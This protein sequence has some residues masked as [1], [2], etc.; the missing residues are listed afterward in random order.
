MNTLFANTSRC[1]F[2][3]LLIPF[4]FACTGLS[5]FVT[6]STEMAGTIP[7]LLPPLSVLVGLATLCL[8]LIQLPFV[9][10]KNKIWLTGINA[11]FF[12]CGFLLW[13]QANVFNWNFGELDGSGVNWD[14]FRYLMWLEICIYVVVIGFILWR[15]Q[16]FS[17]YA[18]QFACV[19]MLMQAIPL[20]LPVANGLAIG[21]PQ[22]ADD[23]PNPNIAS[24]KQYEITYDGFFDYS[25]EQNVVLIIPDCFNTIAFQHIIEKWPEV[26]EWFSDFN[27]FPNRQSD[28]R[29]MVSIPQILTG[30]DTILSLK[31]AD[32][33]NDDASSLSIQRSLWNS[34]GALQKTLTEAGFRT[35]LYVWPKQPHYFDHRWISNIRIKDSTDVLLPRTCQDNLVKAGIGQICDLAIVRSI[36]IV[37][38]PIDIENFCWIQWFFSIDIIGEHDTLHWH[39]LETYRGKRDTFLLEIM[40]RSPASVKSPQKILSVLHL[41]GPH[42]VFDLD[43]NLKIGRLDG[44]DAE[45]RQAFATLRIIKRLMDDMKN[46]DVYDKTLIIVASDHGDVRTCPIYFPHTIVHCNPLFLIK[47]QN[48]RREAMAWRTEHTHNK[49]TTPTILEQL[50]MNSSLPGRFSVFMIPPDVLA[51]RKIE[52]EAMWL[53]GLSPLKPYNVKVEKIKE[54]QPMVISSDIALKRSLLH[55]EDNTLKCYAGDNLNTWNKSHSNHDA[56]IAIIPT[57]GTESYYGT[58]PLRDATEI[59]KYTTY[60]WLACTIDTQNVEDGEYM[61]HF[62]LPKEDATYARSIFPEAIVVMSGTVTIP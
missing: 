32:I 42:T 60:W 11:M 12:G 29:T 38:K 21:Q 13:L 62:L 51:R 31:T 14:A 43:E 1:F 37:C 50:G 15:M 33:Y 46:L 54:R 2:V 41:K 48:E 36:P 45:E 27:Y 5:I 61:V 44:V 59:V 34:E 39:Q 40:D 25:K 4:T 17:K 26:A 49:D 3:A 47:R 23:G 56:V 55:I 22:A 52:Y 57:S 6:N 53:R 7:T 18:I 20:A 58:A 24:W 30:C 16:W 8:F 10:L 28:G 19:L 35:R 9:F